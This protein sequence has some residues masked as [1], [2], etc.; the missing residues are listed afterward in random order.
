MLV[1]FK[2]ITFKKGL[3]ILLEENCY[4]EFKEVK[5]K[6]PKDAIKNTADEY[7][8]AFLNSEGGSIYWGVRNTD[9]IVTG[10]SLEYEE[11]D[12]VRRVVN[13]K[14]DQ[15][16]PA[17]APTLFKIPFHPVLDTNSSE[18]INNLYVVE[19]A[20]PKANTKDLYFTGGNEA[21]VKTDGGKKKLTGPQLTAEVVKRMSQ[22]L[23][24]EEGHSPIPID[25][26]FEQVKRRAKLVSSAIHG[27]QILWVDD[28]PGNNI[29]ERTTL[30]S[31]GIMIDLAISTEE[32]LVLQSMNK[33]DLILSDMG[34]HEDKMAG[35][36]LLNELKKRGILTQVIYYT[37]RSAFENLKIPNG[38]FA[39]TYRP[40]HLLHYIMDVLERTRI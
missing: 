26:P 2:N 37:S 9:R 24:K 16:Q 14:L 20:V 25:L 11:R 5:G 40:D 3:P 6:N 39:I 32:A 35:L 4:Y 30:K 21:F 27:A 8:V 12:E 1:P 33:Y 18:P 36:T 34:R 17:I 7:A 19:L 38:A 29:Y 10:V 28:Y 22:K 31:M 15:I 13:E 23:Y